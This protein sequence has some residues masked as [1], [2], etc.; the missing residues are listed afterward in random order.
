MLSMLLTSTDGCND[1]ELEPDDVQNAPMNA[2]DQE[3]NAVAV[4]AMG[5]ENGN[6]HELL[7]VLTL[8]QHSHLLGDRHQHL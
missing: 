1:M 8:L 4:M 2:T 6:D 7:S 3:L 5:A